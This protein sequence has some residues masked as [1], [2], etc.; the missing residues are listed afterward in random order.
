MSPI[1]LFSAARSSDVSQARACWKWSNFLATL[2]GDKP[3]LRVNLDET[4]CKLHVQPRRGIVMEP[5]SKR[6]RKLLRQGRG[7]SLQQKRAA[8]SLVAFACDDEAVQRQL[9]QIFIVNEHVV[10]KSEVSDLAARCGGGVRFLRRKSSWVNADLMV[11]L[12]K[13]LSRSLGELVRTR[14]VILHMDTHSAHTRAKVL[15]ACGR[16]QLLTHFIPASATGWLQPLD[17]TVF[18]QYK[19]WTVG[20]AERQ[21]LAATSGALSGFDMLDIYRRGV[22]AVIQGRSWAK[23]FEHAGLRGQSGLSAQLLSRLEAASAPVVGS[24]FPTLA[25][26]QACFPKGMDIPIDE[27]FAA[28]LLRPAHLQPPRLKLA[29]SAKLPPLSLPRSR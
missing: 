26:L 11:E 25:E 15:R 27:L 5:C 4:S 21:R 10:K 8:V 3:I 7:P 14:H 12:I 20:E 1:P 9:P 22:E 18:A 28:A 16:A 24:E 6:R 2:A 29:R 13:I 23:A 17:V 19:R